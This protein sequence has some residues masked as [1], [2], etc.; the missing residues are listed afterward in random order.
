V[1]KGAWY[2][3]NWSHAW[4]CILALAVPGL[5]YA[6]ESTDATLWMQT[7]AEYQVVVEQVFREAE[8][9]LPDA[10]AAPPGL[11]AI[12]NRADGAALKPAVVLDIDEAVLDNGAWQAL[13][14]IRG[15][16]GFD[17]V[18]WNKW[19]MSHK[20]E[21]L[22]GALDYVRRARELGIEVFY[23]TNRTCTSPEDCPQKDATI[24]NLTAL[25]FPP[26]DDSRLLMKNDQPGWKSEK[27][28]RMAH[29]AKDFRIVQIIGDDLGD[30]IPGMR[31]ANAEARH[32]MVAP[33][34]ER[35][36]YTWHLIPNPLYGSWM[37]ALGRSP[38]SHLQ[39]D[40]EDLCLGPYTPVGHIQ[41]PGK[42][43]YCTGL[44]VTTRG[45]VTL[46]STG[47]DGLGGYFIQ[48]AED[49][50][51]PA[52]ADG[53][54]VIDR[55]N[56][57]RVSTGDFLEIRAQV[58]ERNGL[59]A[60]K[61]KG[62]SA[63]TLRDRNQSVKPTPIRLP[64]SQE[65]ELERYEGMLVSVAQPMTVTGKRWLAEL[66]QLELA[67]ADDRGRSRRLYQPSHPAPPGS[68]EAGRI[69]K[70]IVH[71]FLVLDD[72]KGVNPDPLPFV[73][74]PDEETTLRVGDQV[75]DILGVLDYGE[76]SP[77]GSGDH[78]FDYR[79]Q[80]TQPPTLLPRNHRPAAPKAG[81]RIEER[82]AAARKFLASI[83]QDK[84]LQAFLDDRLDPLLAR[85]ARARKADVG[86]ALMDLQPGRPARLAH[87][88][89]NTLFYPASVVKFVYLMAAYAWK[90]QGKLR[91]DGALDRQLQ[92]MI[93]KSSNT[94]TQEVVRTLTRTEAGP[95]LTG[96]EYAE[97]RER[98]MGVKRWLEGLGV[99]GIH[100]IH[101][102]Y[103]GDGDL[104]GRDVQLMRDASVKGGLSSSGG[105]FAN[106][107]AMTAV[108]TAK[109]LALLASDLGLSPES[110]AEIRQRMQRDPA[111]QPYQVR[112]IAGG[113]LKTR[114]VEVYSK[115]GT[116]GP[117]FADAGIIRSPSGRQLV[118]AV[119]IDS[120]PAYRGDFIADLARACTSGLLETDG[121]LEAVKREK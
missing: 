11:G 18:A 60:L 85:D 43:S 4:R 68:P 111:K 69:Q 36:G 29:I 40:R 66:G 98:R 41:G 34:R 90:E 103:N 45:I 2:L 61:P 12:E 73:G 59:T 76:I 67:S 32:A 117:I 102:T 99:T 82:A 88:N 35:F 24:K 120:E 19:L 87:W 10:L 112:R 116:W 20:S 108:G 106:R 91:I 22:P 70:E 78:R 49:D 113:A 13:T 86:I 8:R 72:G 21:V 93:Y 25:G 105:N 6:H 15:K 52:T 95:A 92:S 50:N 89:G 79:V 62:R 96:D 58:V 54:F 104:F 31:H 77:S 94:A 27:S 119:F 17:P 97:F 53:I 1:F 44:T 28:N 81:G 121:G 109:L 42:A 9:R 101:P 33:Y 16:H 100:S 5:C 39:P 56:R 80:A 23:V 84:E 63:V 74:K 83:E 7:S 14:I 38:V 65:G 37:K 110:A 30:F 51:N 46:V 26:I 71:R 48:D 118:L 57:S 115:S 114:G 107:Q 75:A 55:M 3:L 47:E 64:E